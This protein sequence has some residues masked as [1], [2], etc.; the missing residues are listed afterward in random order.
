MPPLRILLV[1]DHDAVRETT[2]GMLCDMGHEVDAA[3][4]GPTMLEQLADGARPTT[5]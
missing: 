4:D 2:A 3:A 5:I 1:D